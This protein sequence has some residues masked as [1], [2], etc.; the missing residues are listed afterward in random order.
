MIYG[1]SHTKMVQINLL[2]I[3]LMISEYA[4]AHIFDDVPLEF[5][6]LDLELDDGNRDGVV[7]GIVQ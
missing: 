7:G 1:E 2:G 6:H 5:E 4:L 3:P